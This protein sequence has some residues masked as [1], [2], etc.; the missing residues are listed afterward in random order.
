M[1]ADDLHT[2]LYNYDRAE[3]VLGD[4]DLGGIDWKTCIASDMNRAS[5]TAR[6]VYGGEI[7]YTPLLREPLLGQFRTGNLHLPAW[8]WRQV[9]RVAWLTGHRSQRECRDDFRRRVLA[10]ADRLTAEQQDT[11]VVSHAGM[12]LY[13]SRELRRRGFAGPKLRIA[14]HAVVYIYDN[15]KG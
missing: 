4:F 6:H 10:M 12:M 8:V 15:G 9:L 1:S 7:E 14:Q 11:L 2:W 13:L 3:V 5:A